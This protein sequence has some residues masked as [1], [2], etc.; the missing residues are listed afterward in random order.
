VP[1]RLAEGGED[2]FQWMHR[3]ADKQG[4]WLFIPGQP[5]RAYVPRGRSA[6]FENDPAIDWRGSLNVATLGTITKS[7]LTSFADSECECEIWADEP[8]P[9]P[10]IFNLGTTDEIAGY[11]QGWSSRANISLSIQQSTTHY[12]LLYV[13]GA[14]R[15]TGAAEPADKVGIKLD[16][17]HEKGVGLVALLFDH[18]KVPSAVGD[19]IEGFLDDVRLRALA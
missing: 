5:V 6:D 9:E 4:E 7:L 14:L 13:W 16:L 15:E 11:V 2:F 8:A 12:P 17:T 19:S 18:T 1:E 10:R 3:R